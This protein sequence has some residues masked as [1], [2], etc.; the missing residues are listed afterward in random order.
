M[1]DDINEKNIADYVMF[2]GKA[3]FQTLRNEEMENLVEKGRFPQNWS[4]NISLSN[5]N[6]SM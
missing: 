1:W 5:H 3:I 6:N 2:T 4:H